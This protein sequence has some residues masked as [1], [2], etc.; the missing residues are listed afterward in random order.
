MPKS[1]NVFAELA[2]LLRRLLHSPD[3]SCLISA[4][5]ACMIDF[6]CKATFFSMFPLLFSLSAGPSFAGN[7]DI[8]AKNEYAQ[9]LHDLQYN[10]Y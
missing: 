10:H 1:K 3:A 6:L 2:G 5:G 9:V 8:F 7:S 4:Q